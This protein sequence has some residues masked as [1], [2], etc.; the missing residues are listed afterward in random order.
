MSVT[1]RITR[2]HQNLGKLVEFKWLIF[3]TFPDK[4]WSLTATAC[5]ESFPSATLSMDSCTA[6]CERKY[7]AEQNRSREA[8][9]SFARLRWER[10]TTCP[11]GPGSPGC[12]YTLRNASG[13]P[14]TLDIEVSIEVTGG[15]SRWRGTVGKQNAGGLCLQSFS[16]PTLESLRFTRN[17]ERLFAPYM[18]GAAGGDPEF[19]WNS[20]GTRPEVAAVHGVGQKNRSDLEQ[21][22]VPNGWDR[23][24]GWA[25]WF[26]GTGAGNTTTRSGIGLY[27]GMHDPAGRL[28]MLPVGFESTAARVAN[29]RAVHVPDTFDDGSTNDFT[30][31]YEVVLAAFAGGWWEA[32]Q[33]YRDWAVTDAAWTRRG[34]LST[35]A[36]GVPGWLLRAPL[37]LRL[38]YVPV[39]GN[40]TEALVDGVREVLG[41]P[42]SAVTD[43]GLHWYG[44]NV[45]KFDTHYPIY[46]PKPGFAAA[47]ARLQ[48]AHAG[49]TA[50]V[51]P[52][53]NG[54]LWDPAGPLRPADVPA[55]ATCKGRAGTAYHEVY[56]SGVIFNVMD[57]AS[58]FMQRTWSA[59][60]GNISAAYNVSGVYADQI[61]CAHA[62]ACYASGGST[63]ASSWTAGS[64]AM[65]AQMAGRMGPGKVLISESQ[66]ETMLGGLDAFLA[67]YGWAGEM[68]CQTAL[69]WQAVYGG[70]A[71]NVGDIR[72]PRQP[73]LATTG[74]K[75]VMNAT[76]AAAHR[77]ISAQLFVSGSVLGWFEASVNWENYLGLPAADAAFTRLLASTKATAMAS[78]YL[79]FG[80]LWRP[81][82]WAIPVE[83]MQ[84]HDYGYMEHQ[85]NQSCPTP[86]VL[87]ECWLADDGTLA[88]V[89]TNHAT[90]TFVLNVSVDVSPAH[91]A[92]PVIVAVVATMPGRSVRILP[93][94][95][96]N[97]TDALYS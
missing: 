9:Y 60:V 41:G 30:V 48:T 8:G 96:L 63:N 81:P 31:P 28:K 1:S 74:G 45:E 75:L 19:P 44:W 88:V 90:T 52:Y 10:C 13:L 85:W 40:Y 7:V 95:E 72:Y 83:M 50:R 58:A 61:S 64:Q 33:L 25:A 14:A 3:S 11:D 77:A 26:S 89:A 36:A 82:V 78:K 97:E 65:L 12:G 80:R 66:A 24:M 42:G 71:V 37:W 76:E 20:A 70:W 47:V 49:V 6:S 53:T 46:T 4:V 29:L 56:G 69:A 55:E 91:S 62:E 86:K 17:Q 57:P 43:I 21:A 5:N 35:R 51:V 79:T 16:M 34:N 22:W 67:I 38:S 93:V 54:R 2:L 92:Q 23:T 15:R 68:R 39:D 32:A 27:L 94:T 87:A 59:A 84:V 73:R 18:F